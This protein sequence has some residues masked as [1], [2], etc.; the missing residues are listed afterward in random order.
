MIESRATFLRTIGIIV[1][2]RNRVNGNIM[3]N[4][5]LFVLLDEFFQFF[6]ICPRKLVDLVSVL[7]EDESRHA[8]DSILAGK[9][10]TNIKLVN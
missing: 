10:K 4:I 5:S 1:A 9:H 6:C 8:R 2:F 7:D 3:E